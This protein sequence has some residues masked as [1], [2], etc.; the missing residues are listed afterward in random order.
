[1]KG[2]HFNFLFLLFSVC[3][4]TL[5]G[6]SNKK[7]LQLDAIHSI[8]LGISADVYVTQS[9]RQSVSVEG[10]QRLINQLNTNVKN[11]SWNIEYLDKENYSGKLKIYM[12]VASL[13]EL[14]IGGS[15]SIRLQSDFNGLDELG[16]AIGGNGK[17]E[18]KGDA[19]ELSISIGGNGTVQAA[20][21][22]ATNCVIS[23]AGN[24]ECDV[25][26]E[27]KLE[28]SI[29]GMGKVNYAGS[30]RLSQSI[31]GFGKVRRMK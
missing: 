13:Q 4:I 5:F 8:G 29:A 2:Y 24:G 14:A 22:K 18:L 12:S 17:I 7:D 31:A 9:N 16:V 11:G 27:D 3:S 30:P 6:Q 20:S 10:P 19:K 1:M 26:V 23:I 28:V 15:G 25:D 21:M